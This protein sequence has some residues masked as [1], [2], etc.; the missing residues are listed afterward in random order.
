M[1]FCPK[2]NAELAEDSRF[3]T[4]CGSDIAAAQAETQ[5]CTYSYAEPV[6]EKKISKSLSIQAM[7]FG[8]V[9][10]VMAA[11]CFSYS[12]IVCLPVALVFANLSKKRRAAWI[13]LAGADNGF[14][15]AGNIT[16]KIAIP[17]SIVLSA[18]AAV[19]VIVYVIVYVAA[20]GS[21]AAGEMA[22]FED[23]VE[24]YYDI[25]E[26]II[27]FFVDIIESIFNL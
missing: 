14:T 8:I 1:S 12:F 25:F 22:F 21:M 24:M 27:D 3:C 9:A 7:I 19:Y 4:E 11:S 6:K 2:C 5:Q 23:M 20:V 15:K 16:S 26:E 13:D 18:L 10:L 17:V